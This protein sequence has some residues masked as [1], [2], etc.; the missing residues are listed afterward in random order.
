MGLPLS[1]TFLHLNNN[2]YYLKLW[3]LLHTMWLGFLVNNFVKYFLVPLKQ[4]ENLRLSLTHYYYNTT[5][6]EESLLVY[7]LVIL[8]ITYSKEQ[9]PWN[10]LWISFLKRGLGCVIRPLVRRG[11]SWL[12]RLKRH[13]VLTVWTT[14]GDK[15]KKNTLTDSHR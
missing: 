12:L 14:S 5:I 3:L 1:W 15:D 10:S 11:S 9:Q 4:F 2:Y 8:S 6:R 7:N 13:R